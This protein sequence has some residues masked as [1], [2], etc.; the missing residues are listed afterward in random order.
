MM[1]KTRA[2][3]MLALS[4]LLFSA[5]SCAKK[6]AAKP[7]E[8]P[9][10]QPAPPAPLAVA[11]I[12][13]GKAVSA[14]KKV[15]APAMAFGVRDTIYASV[16][17]TGVGENA[18]IGAKWTFVKADG[19]TIA[20]NETSQTISSTGG[21]SATEFHITKA[22]PWPKGKYRVEVTLNG[23]LAGSKEFEVQ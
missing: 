19:S 23:A 1:Q 13:L 3:T 9:A 6:E 21:P 2:A 4:A 10:A 22:S 18:T 14:D 16:S 20:V 12:D 8:A 11:A 17:T 15:V 5:S 7:A